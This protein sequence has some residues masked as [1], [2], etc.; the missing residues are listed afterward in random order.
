MDPGS[1]AIFGY[2]MPLFA[3]PLSIILIHERPRT[4]NVIGGAIIGFIGVII[5]GVSSI[6]RGGVSLIARCLRWLMPYFGPYIVYTLGSWV[7]M[8]G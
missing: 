5:Y 7:I 8:M 4:L 2:T 1:S 3:I 6:I